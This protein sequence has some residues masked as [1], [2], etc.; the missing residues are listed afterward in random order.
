MNIALTGGGT[1]GH[2]MPN[3]ALAEALGTYFDKIIY[4]GSRQS[5]EES[6]CREQNLPYYPTETIKFDRKK[7]WRNIAI[8][9]SLSRGKREA[10]RILIEEGI[11]IVFSKGGY[12]SLP[13]VLAARSLSIPV[14]CHESDRTLGLANRVA[15]RFA[16][17][18][19]TAFP[20]TDKRGIR[21]PTPIRSKIFK[22]EKMHLFDNAKPIVLFM[23]GSLGAKT[24]NDALS[25]CLA[26]LTAR[27][28]ILHI[29]GK[30]TTP[31][32]TTSYV[33][34]PYAEDIENYFAT[35]DVVVSRG[36][37]ST[38]GE[39]TALRKKTLVIPLPKGTSRGDQVLNAAY[40]LKDGSVSVLPQE[41]LTTDSLLESI[42]CT[43]KKRPPAPTYTREIPSILA[44]ELCEIAKSKNRRER[45]DR[46]K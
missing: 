30:G 11:D 22:G 12:A 34:V 41:A 4:L 39:L 19:Y 16:E 29:G 33:S 2:I 45:E 38:L 17:R 5:M 10:K 24:I 1:A 20:N 14:V 15:A 44:R 35:A 3:I 42:A 31:M 28:N 36:G 21:M 37:A 25:A 23:G 18:I 6:I 9:L 13:A 46:K 40:Y 27:Y 32:K 43:I 26:D 7:L 8:P